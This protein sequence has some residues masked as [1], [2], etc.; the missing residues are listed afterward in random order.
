MKK[1]KTDTFLLDRNMDLKKGK[2]KK[3]GSVLRQGSEEE[4]EEKTSGFE[5]RS[6]KPLKGK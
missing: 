1:K 6:M 3:H 2:K 5:E 4:E